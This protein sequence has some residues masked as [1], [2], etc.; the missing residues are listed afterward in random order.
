MAATVL[1]VAAIM[2][3]FCL[4]EHHRFEWKLMAVLVPCAVGGEL[5]LEFM[6]RRRPHTS[7]GKIVTTW[8]DFAVMIAV[9]AVLI[10][11]VLLLAFFL[12][13]P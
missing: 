3:A 4:S 1:I 8:R 10:S 2:A 6:S 7:D 13:A 9:F 5:Y 12:W 11:V